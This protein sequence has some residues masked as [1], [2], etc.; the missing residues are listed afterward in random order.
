M[1]CLE[2]RV[3]MI[4]GGGG[5]IGLG[6][7]RRFAKEGATIMIAECRADVGERVAQDLHS[8]FGVRAAFTA[9]DVTVK[10]QVQRLVKETVDRFGA[11]DILINNAGG[12]TGLKPLDQTTEEEI[13]CA[14]N[15]N[16][17]STYWAMQAAYPY[18]REKGWGRIVNL[19]SLN[20][21]NAHMHTTPYNVGKEAMRA[22]T[23]TAAVEWA[24]YGICCNVICP[25]ARTAAFERFENTWPEAAAAI[26]RQ[27]PNRRM[28]DP[29]Q[30]IAGVALF[31]SSDDAAHVVGMTIHADGGSHVNGVAWRP[32]GD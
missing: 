27:V 5:G 30:D 12:G 14:L 23:R 8:E 10:D 6:I 15:L 2:G 16:F 4:T 26:T 22:L 25:G 13:V 29:E 31:L 24:R 1:G 9:T 11:L 18:M 3:A 19:G 7:A 21:V 17:W 28:G 32:D 20:G